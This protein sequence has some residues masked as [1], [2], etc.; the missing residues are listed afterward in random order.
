MKIPTWYNLRDIIK[1][2]AALIHL[3]SSSYA[4]SQEV[5]FNSSFL[6]LVDGKKNEEIDLSFFS[7][8]GGV[9]PGVYELTVFVNDEKVDH[10]TINFIAEENGEKTVV[11]CVTREQMY[12]WK[13]NIND[14]T[15]KQNDSCIKITSEL[16]PSMTT[17]LD[18]NKMEYK[19]TVPQIYITSNYWYRTSPAQWQN[20]ITSLMVN[21]YLSGSNNGVFINS[22]N[23]SQSN[24]LGVESLFNLDGWR[25]YNTSNWIKDNR[26]EEFQSLRTW[27]QKSYTFAQGGELTIGDNYI[28]NDFFDTFKF[29]GIKIESDDS[30]LS[31]EFVDYS[32]SIRGIAYSPSRV[33]VRQ[34]DQV[35]YETN[36]PP[37]EFELKDFSIYNG[38]DLDITIKE[39]DGTERHY[40]QVSAILP[41]LQREGR[42]KYSASLGKYDDNN[43]V[44]SPFIFNFTSAYGISPYYTIYSGG[45]LSS[46]Y[47]SFLIGG[48]WYNELLGA[49]SLDTTWSNAELNTIDNNYG[50]SKGQLYRISYARSLP[51]NATFNITSYKHLKKGFFSFPDAI[52]YIDNIEF[53]RMKSRQ[54]VS[55]YQPLKSYGQLS[56]SGS[57][58]EFWDTNDTR[59]LY[60]IT[61]NNTFN[62]LSVALN[63]SYSDAV[64]YHDKIV[65]LS[66]SLPLSALLADNSNI[67][68]NN[69]TSSIDGAVSNQSS[70]SG[71]VMN[72]GLNWS[73]SNDWSGSELQRSQSANLM[74]NSSKAQISS[75]YARFHNNDVF[76]YGLRGGVALHSGG[77]TLSQPLDLNGGNALINTKGLGGVPV[78]GSALLDTDYFGYA[79]LPGVP[80]FQKSDISLD[81]N[82]FNE[83]MESGSTD[84]M[85]IPSRGTLIPVE[86]NV[87]KGLRAI[88]TLKNN[89]KKLP[90]GAI[91]QVN[92]NGRNINGIVDDNGQ[93]YLSGL[94]ESGV[95]H[96]VWGKSKSCR[97]SYHIHDSSFQKVKLIC[98]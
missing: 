74:W 39:A 86:F 30:M 16:Y 6:S 57:R 33:I 93:V 88:I 63:M 12:R 34:S 2:I 45:I 22:D 15:Y 29:K 69:I 72:N 8:K 56:F 43:N 65:S 26:K 79:V 55:L 73:V 20:G 41:V 38:A 78:K 90:L 5:T 28:S 58:D 87:S 47:N 40:K 85:I 84:K 60:T 98:E 9:L 7:K 46:S 51:N 68:F 96:A 77:I 64:D 52:N 31:S 36:V 18:L 42:L 67:S 62:M 53:I 10:A 23:N 50:N 13:I 66:F 37:G 19:I 97:T 49:I 48:G 89:G 91:V 24:F 44:N 21:Y 4:L 25:L 1:P 83:N 3:C 92:G 35:V 11:P 81:V 75:G 80:V 94:P 14:K 71:S 70:I 59:E 54:V 61:W 95:I 32:P 82:R 27:L 17:S 76:N